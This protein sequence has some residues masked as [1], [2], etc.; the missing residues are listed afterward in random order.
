V[1]KSSRMSALLCACLLSAASSTALAASGWTNAG[2]ITELNQQPAVGSGASM[3]FLEVGVTS[4]PTNP[5]LCT[6]RTGFYFSVTDDRRK[7]LFASLLAAQMSG[8]P[9]KIWANENCHAW[10]HA[11]LDGLIIN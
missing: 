3:V 11:E 5:S 6:Y 2:Q 7:R 4:N 1:I 9:V 8:K 10:G